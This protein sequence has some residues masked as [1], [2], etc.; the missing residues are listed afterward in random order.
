[1]ETNLNM[2][3]DQVSK[4]KGIDRQVLVQALEEAILASAKE[5]LVLSGICTLSTMRKRV[6][7]TLVRP[8]RLSKLSIHSTKLHS[9]NALSV[10]L[11]SNLRWWSFHLLPRGR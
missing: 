1:M 3:I 7:L 11:T 5:R 10:R 9:K 4:D 6:R 2:V 8:S